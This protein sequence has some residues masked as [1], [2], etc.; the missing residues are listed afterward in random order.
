M[1]LIT[2]RLYLCLQ[3]VKADI[4]HQCKDMLQQGIIRLNTRCSPCRS[5]ESCD[6]FA[7]KL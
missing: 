5:S 2:V 4:E 6:Q 1:A 3:L 7:C